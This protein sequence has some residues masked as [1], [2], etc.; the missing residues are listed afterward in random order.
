MQLERNRDHTVVA[1]AGNRSG[2][3]AVK[4][5]ISATGVLDLVGP[6]CCFP[7][8]L[9]GALTPGFWSLDKRKLTVEVPATLPSATN[10]PGAPAGHGPPSLKQ[11][12]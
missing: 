1:K 7:P 9:L 6:V 11:E 4:R 3:S 5:R 12:K 10:L 8:S 2:Q